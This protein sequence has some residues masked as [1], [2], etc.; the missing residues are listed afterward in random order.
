VKGLHDKRFPGESEAY[1]SARDELLEAEIKLSSQVEEVAAVRRTL[2]TG[3]RL[4]EDYLFQELSRDSAGRDEA[5]DIRFSELFGPGKDTLVIYG[6]MFHPD[7]ERPC[8]SCSSI[9]DGLNGAAPHL[10]DTINFVAIAKASVPK[11]DNWAG[12]RGWNKLRLLSSGNNTFNRDYFAENAN[13]DQLPAV[14]VFHKTPDGI[15]HFYNTELLYLPAEKG[16]DQRHV[17]MMWP[18]W[19]V[20][21]LTPDGRGTKWYPKYY[22]D[23]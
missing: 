23:K 12:D 2:P 8:T 21:D 13:G 9:L 7:H 22:Y 19:N 16:Q 1:R 14:N 11:I 3:G 5:K 20:L 17:D 18:V 10:N 15:F 6:W 4:K